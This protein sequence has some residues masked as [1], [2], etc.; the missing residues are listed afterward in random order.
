MG[1]DTQNTKK[2][3]PFHVETS[4]RTDGLRSVLNNGPKKKA[5]KCERTN[6]ILISRCFIRFDAFFWR[7]MNE[8]ANER[9]EI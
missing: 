3:F 9:L 6:G 7:L 4:H 8:K 2:L 1:N 5:T